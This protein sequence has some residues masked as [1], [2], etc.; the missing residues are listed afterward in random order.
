MFE[1]SHLRWWLSSFY[2]LLL[3]Q[4]LQS[5]LMLLSFEVTIDNS[6]C[7]KAH[8]ASPSVA[9]T[10]SYWLWC[11]SLSLALMLL[12]WQTWPSVWSLFFTNLLY[13]TILCFIYLHPIEVRFM[14]V[15]HVGTLEEPGTVGAYDSNYTSAV[16]LDC[17]YNDIIVILFT[18]VL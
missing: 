12:I 2:T 5:L 3:V 13:Y 15:Q 18:M 1:L 10:S 17:S 8:S 7:H 6:A 4:D 16:L 14:R 11:L 9:C